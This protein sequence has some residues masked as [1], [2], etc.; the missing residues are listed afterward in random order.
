[1]VAPFSTLP[2]G[3]TPKLDAFALPAW[4]QDEQGTGSISVLL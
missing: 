2:G 3:N 1:M 4:L